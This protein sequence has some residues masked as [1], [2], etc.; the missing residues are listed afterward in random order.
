MIILNYLQN[1][2]ST[3]TYGSTA[4]I[5]SSSLPISGDLAQKNLYGSPI[6]RNLYRL[7]AVVVHS[8][9]ANSG[10]FITYRRGVMRNS[11]RYIS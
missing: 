2:G 7:L 4:S 10:H 9:E 8:G 1:G 6:P 3:N 11:H 5:I